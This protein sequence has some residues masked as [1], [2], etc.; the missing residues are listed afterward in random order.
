M[1]EKSDIDEKMETITNGFADQVNALSSS[2]MIRSGLAEV[3][4]VEAIWA[5]VYAM[6]D[7]Q[8]AIA[9]ALNDMDNIVRK[10]TIEKPADAA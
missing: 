5:L 4:I 10:A 6:P 7:C 9:D 3:A 1:T 8:I 2:P